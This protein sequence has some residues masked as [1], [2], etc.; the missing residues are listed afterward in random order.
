M[1]KESTYFA[2]GFCD[3]KYPEI[4]LETHIPFHAY[5]L[6]QKHRAKFLK[7]YLLGK[8]VKR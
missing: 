6:M 5:H 2:C 8:L 7:L 3:E 1:S 4:P